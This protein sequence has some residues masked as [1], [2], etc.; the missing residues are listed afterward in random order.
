M[1]PDEIA[2]RPYIVMNNWGNCKV[3][4]KHDDLRC[5]TCFTCAEFVDGERI[6]RTTHRLWDR[7]NPQNTWFYSETGDA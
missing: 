4:G 7:R 3:C 5:G 1:T 6:S 2:A